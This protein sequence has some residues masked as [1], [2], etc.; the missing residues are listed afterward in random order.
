MHYKIAS[1]EGAYLLQNNSTMHGQPCCYVT[2]NQEVNIHD[3]IFHLQ[4]T[5]CNVTDLGNVTQTEIEYP[6]CRS[7]V[8]SVSISGGA[9]CYNGTTVGSKA[10]YICN[11]GLILM[12][13]EARVCQGD[14]NWNGSIP[15]CMPE[16]SSMFCSHAIR[17]YI[18]FPK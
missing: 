2:S 14:G 11:D 17:F 16:K 10:V 3:C 7:S 1:A 5:D 15:R 8:S 13:N 6:M 9:V 4:H 18:T 12:G